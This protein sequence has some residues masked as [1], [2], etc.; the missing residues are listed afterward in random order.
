MALISSVDSRLVLLNARRRLKALA[1]KY[2]R[3]IDWN[4][5]KLSQSYLRSEITL[6]QTG[7]IF[8]F[9]II[10]NDAPNSNAVGSKQLLLT[11][12]DTFFVSHLG[13]F[14]L[15]ES[16]A[17]YT[18]P[19]T[20][21][22]LLANTLMTFPSTALNQAGETGFDLNRLRMLWN[23]KLTLTVDNRVITPQWDTLR[24]YVTPQTQRG[25]FTLP[26]ANYQFA[27]QLDGGQD[28]FYPVEPNWM[29]S[30]SKNNQFQFI[31]PEPLGDPSIPNNDVVKLVCIFRGVLAQN[32]TSI[33]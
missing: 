10:T 29:L 19:T 27:D 6:S 13:I 17:N 33:F 18:A 22:A 4:T 9:P 28:G 12:Q 1:T 15:C 11:L 25:Q 20:R 23:A 26:P 30:G 3:T 32:S 31:L 2:K 21:A 24:H 16:S 14:L 8:Q 7:T 5:T